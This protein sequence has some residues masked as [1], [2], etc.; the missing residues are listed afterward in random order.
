M[1]DEVKYREV[2]NNLEQEH[3]VTPEAAA[4]LLDWP[5]KLDAT[6]TPCAGGKHSPLPPCKTPAGRADGGSATGH[7]FL[8]PIGRPNRSP[9]MG[10]RI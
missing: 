6:P 7:G 5:S 1:T 3:A 10:A 9:G 8:V 4:Q 2:L